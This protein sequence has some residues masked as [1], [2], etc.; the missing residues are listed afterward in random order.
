ME[1]P[2]TATV[3]APVRGRRWPLFAVGVLLFVLGPVGYFV[4]L[5]ARYLAT[6]W[7]A[8]VLAL[9]GLVLMSA[10]VRRQPGAWRIVAIVPFVLLC[11]LEWFFVLVAVQTPAYVGPAKPGEKLPGFTTTLAD[12]QPFSNND[13]ALGKPTAL[14]FFRGRW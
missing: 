14:V 2:A 7:H 3:A 6:P 8:P 10:S 1:N 9:L 4:M 5:K 11:V 12:G 13:L